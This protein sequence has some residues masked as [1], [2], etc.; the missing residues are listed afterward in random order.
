M[1][2]LLLACFQGKAAE[3][4]TVL[5]VKNATETYFRNK[6][7]TPFAASIELVF[8]EED[9]IQSRCSGALLFDPL[10]KKLLMECYG[11]SGFPV[12][13][14]K[15][16]D[17]HFVLYLPGR[18][19]AWAGDIFQLEYSDDFSGYLRPL[20]LYRAVS[21]EPFSEGQAIGAYGVNEGM[22]LEIAKPYQGSR[23]LARRMIVNSRG[24]VE[25]ESFMTPDG[26]I[27][28]VV[29]R[30][31]FEKIKNKLDHLNTKFYYAPQTFVVHPETGHRTLLQI[32]K[33]VLYESFPDE[34][35]TV[36]IPETISIESVR[37]KE[38]AGK[39]I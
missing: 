14:F 37:I 15:N 5:E 32:K 8:Y 25:H 12:F 38:P 1:T 27:K 16:D 10:R 30:E 9:A 31:I 26:D 29:V 35:W 19:K 22:E 17:V 7:W 6:N 39:Q 21:P 18:E 2:A 24:Q 3:F 33:V 23:Y 4:K 20:D 28:T 11:E 34:A 13:I 36:R